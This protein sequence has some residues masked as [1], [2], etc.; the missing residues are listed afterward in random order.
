MPRGGVLENRDI[1]S[2]IIKQEPEFNIES[3]PQ[4]LNLSSIYRQ[5]LSATKDTQLSQTYYQ[6]QGSTYTLHQGGHTP[7]GICLSPLGLIG[8]I[9]PS[10]GKQVFVNTK[11]PGNVR[12]SGRVV[13]WSGSSSR[14]EAILANFPI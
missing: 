13:Y 7:H 14:Q 6:S 10:F 4:I 8:D 3:S 2:A 9:K 5:P 11:I 12:V 1:C